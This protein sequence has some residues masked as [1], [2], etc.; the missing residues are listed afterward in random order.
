MILIG[1]DYRVS[2]FL[3]EKE[4]NS[5]TLSMVFQARKEA[6]TGRLT[7]AD[8]T[9]TKFKDMFDTL[10]E[11]P[12]LIDPLAFTPARQFFEELREYGEVARWILLISA[13]ARANSSIWCSGW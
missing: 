2:L 12:G 6:T 3:H 5:R 9:S 7:V 10:Q 13:P 4:R 11:S 8:Q 1:F